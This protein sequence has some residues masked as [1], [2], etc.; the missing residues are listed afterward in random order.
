MRISTII[1][2]VLSGCTS[3]DYPIYH[4][5]GPT[6]KPGQWRAADIQYITY[7]ANVSGN[8]LTWAENFRSKLYVAP[9]VVIVHGNYEGNVWTAYP[10]G[11]PT[12]P[13]VILIANLKETCPNR[14]IILISCNARGYELKVPGVWYAR[15]KVWCRPFFMPF[16]PTVGDS[17]MFEE[18]KP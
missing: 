14:P 16:D 9:L 1:I 3:I 13:M 7:C 10:D 15:Q 18:S 2:L 17:S 5:I 6:T 8:E 11:L 12:I 4:I